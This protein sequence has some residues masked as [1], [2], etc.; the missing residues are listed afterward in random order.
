MNITSYNITDIS[1]HYVGLRVLNGMPSTAKRGEQIEAISRSVLKLVR[2]RALRLMLPEPTGTFK[3]VGGKICQ[4]LSHF[5]FARSKSGRYELTQAGEEALYLLNSQQITDLRRLMVRVHLQTYDNLRVMVRTHLENGPI[6]SPIVTSERLSQVDDYVQRLLEPTFGKDAGIIAAEVLDSLPRKSPSK[7]ED[8][9]RAKILGYI[10]PKQ[11]MRTALFRAMSDRLISLRLLNKPRI[12]LR[13]CE[14]DKTYSP[15]VIGVP[16]RPWY[17]ILK[18]PLADGE[19]YEFYFCEPDMTKK[20]HQE[21]LLEAIDKAFSIL[22]MVS[23]YYD[24]PDLRDWVCKHLMIPEAAFDDGI[25]RLLDRTPPLLSV[26]LHYDKITS[27]RKPLV[28][29]SQTAQL[30][31]LIRRF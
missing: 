29:T 18:I 17:E 6:L 19:F 5:Q 4:E 30:H 1:Y 15:C 27:Q 9:L 24:I 20:D 16:Q 2:D 28:R 12:V 25:N 22:P 8:A 13:K 11:K 7:I 21:L 26:G 31:N 14:F 10:M 3:T 23:G